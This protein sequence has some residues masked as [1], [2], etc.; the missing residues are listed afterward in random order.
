MVKVLQ[1]QQKITSRNKTESFVNDVLK[2]SGLE[3]E[4]QYWLGMRVFDFFLLKQGV[5]IEMDG[6]WHRP[7]LDYK[8]DLF[9]REEFG[10]LTYRI[11]NKDLNKIFSFIEEIENLSD[12]Q[13]RAKKFQRDQVEEQLAY[14]A[15]FNTVDDFAGKV[16][17][18]K[19]EKTVKKKKKRVIYHTK[20][21]LVKEKIEENKVD[22]SLAR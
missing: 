11:P 10:V 20:R 21:K 13:L 6:K 3:F 17:L 12:W 4:S 7:G 2:K 19:T 9:F 16:I 5:A 18:K 22:A 1:Q 14:Q 8:K 15:K